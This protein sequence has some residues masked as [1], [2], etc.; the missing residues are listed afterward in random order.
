MDP[1]GTLRLARFSYFVLA[2]I[3]IYVSECFL[4]S[5]NKFLLCLA[6]D[7]LFA[8]VKSKSLKHARSYTIINFL[9]FAAV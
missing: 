2:C 9:G 3:F 5:S 7:F 6:V 4:V 8:S 1:P